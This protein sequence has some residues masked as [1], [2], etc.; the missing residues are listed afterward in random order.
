MVDDIYWIKVTVTYSCG[1]ESTYTDTSTT[2]ED[3]N[4]GVSSYSNCEKRGD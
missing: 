4:E 2:P 1:I 3:R